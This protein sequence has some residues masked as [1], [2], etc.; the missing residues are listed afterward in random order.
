M[1]KALA[2]IRQSELPHLRKAIPMAHDLAEKGDYRSAIRLCELALAAMDDDLDN[3]ELARQ[4]RGLIADFK[5]RRQHRTG[6]NVRHP[7]R[8]AL[9]VGRRR[10][11]G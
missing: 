2:E 11:P 10:K 5:E 7:C 4:L 1:L 6:G 3:A 9:S 8:I